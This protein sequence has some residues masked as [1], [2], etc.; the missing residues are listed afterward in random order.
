MFFFFQYESKNNKC[1]HKEDILE[2]NNRTFY[3]V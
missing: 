1:N 3:L 2:Y